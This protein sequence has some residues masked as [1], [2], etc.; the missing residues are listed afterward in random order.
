MDEL[1]AYA[2]VRAGPTEAAVDQLGTSAD[3]PQCCAC[4]AC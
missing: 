4:R 1:S 2:E 3:L